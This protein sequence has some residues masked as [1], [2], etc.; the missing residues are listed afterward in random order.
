MAAAQIGALRV[1][2]GLDTAQFSS[3]L[4][5]V[6]GKINGFVAAATAG[7]AAVGAAAALS[8]GKIR[9]A[10][11]R[12]DQ[13][14]KDSQ[15]LGVP[16]GELGRLSYAADMSGVAYD[17]LATAV[18]KGSQNIGEAVSKGSGKAADGFKALNVGLKNSD[19]STRSFSAILGD[20]AERFRVMPNGVGKTSLAM[21]IFGKSGAALIPMLN[22]GRAGIKALGDEAQ[23]LGLVFDEKT[24]RSAE[25]FNDNLQR[26]SMVLTGLWNKVLAQV[27]PAFSDLSGKMFDATQEGG[28]L[29]MVARGISTAM[30]VMARAVGFV[31]DHLSDLFDLLKVFVA[32]KSILFLTGLAGSFINLAKTV[33]IAGVAMAI[34]TSLAKIKLTAFVLLGAVILKVTNTF[35]GFIDGLQRLGDAIYEALPDNMKDGLNTMAGGLDSLAG[36]IDGVNTVVDDSQLSFRAWGDIAADSFGTAAGGAREFEGAV[37]GIGMKVTTLADTLREVAQAASNGLSGFVRDAIRGDDA[38]GNLISAVGTLGDRLTSMAIDQAIN[39]FLQMV[40]SALTGS[41]AGFSYGPGVFSDPWAGMRLTAPSFEGGGYTGGGSRTGGL[42]GRGGFAAILHPDETVFDH[43]SD[44]GTSA[45]GAREVRISVGVS[46]NGYLRPYIEEVA[47]A[48]SGN[49][50]QQFSRM[51]LPDRVHGIIKDPYRRGG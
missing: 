31:F 21:D 36:W 41:G 33:R 3:G 48:V 34:V 15:S 43:E 8:F 9:E 38:V 4:K 11:D 37:D 39:G 10:A 42:D 25:V 13:A 28:G 27:I 7:L 50:I 24:A 47:G 17:A 44:R 14:W 29:D 40:V 46:E 6:S 32:A 20:V 30:N 2:L 16:I 45:G 26:M 23:R 22:E 18:R 12:A 1:S 51:A 35:D 19:G 5:G 49:Q